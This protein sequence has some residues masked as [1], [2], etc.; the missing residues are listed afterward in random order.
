[1][2]PDQREQLANICRCVHT[3]DQDRA[4]LAAWAASLD[5]E[6]LASV[7]Q[8]IGAGCDDGGVAFAWINDGFDD[9]SKERRA[10]TLCRLARVGLVAM[11]ERKWDTE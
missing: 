6:T 2:S 7:C 8:C 11:C 5:P 10:Q 3:I 9:E 1:M 4:T